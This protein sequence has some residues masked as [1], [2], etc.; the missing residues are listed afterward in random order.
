MGLPTVIGA[1][2]E[3]MGSFENMQPEACSGPGVSFELGLEGKSYLDGD[4][5]SGRAFQAEEEP[6]CRLMGQGQGDWYFPGLMGG[7]VQEHF[8]PPHLICS[9]SHSKSHAGPIT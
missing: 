6:G 8:H 7:R 4:R 2:K 1:M 3:H 5:G 9:F